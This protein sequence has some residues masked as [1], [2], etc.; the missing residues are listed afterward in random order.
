MDH[1]TIDVLEGMRGAFAE[2][3]GRVGKPLEDIAR[4]AGQKAAQYRQLGNAYVDL[5]PGNGDSYKIVLHDLVAPLMGEARRQMR[6]DCPHCDGRGAPDKGGNVPCSGGCDLDNKVPAP[7][8]TET[9][10]RD[11]SYSRSMAARLGGEL[12]VSLPELGSHIGS[13][14][15][16]SLAVSVPA[17]VTPDWLM[18]R[19][20][21]LGDAI[22][23]AT[24]LTLFSD[25]VAEQRS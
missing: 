2:A 17:F 14:A 7:G 4:L 16:V 3:G 12:L 11:W 6:V 9:D 24:F 23:V 5:Q 10:L 15:G 25:A 20:L 22:H 8:V 13:V 21:R 19:G 1:V 18:Q